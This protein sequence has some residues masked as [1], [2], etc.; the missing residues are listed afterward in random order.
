M[1]GNMKAWDTF[2]ICARLLFSLL[3]LL[4]KNVLQFKLDLLKKRFKICG[5]NLSE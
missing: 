3:I 5:G 4:R 2:L 1:L